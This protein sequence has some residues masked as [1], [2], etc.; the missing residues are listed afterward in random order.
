MYSSQFPPLIPNKI[1]AAH[2]LQQWG[3]GHEESPMTGHPLHQASV[4]PDSALPPLPAGFQ[5]PSH[6]VRLAPQYHSYRPPQQE[7]Q[8]TDPS[9]LQPIRSHQDQYPFPTQYPLPKHQDRLCPPPSSSCEPQ[10]QNFPIED[11]QF[12]AEQTLGKTDSAF[13]ELSNS[14]NIW[15]SI[16][17]EEEDI[18][19]KIKVV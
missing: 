3:F 7:A 18:C 1:V 4:R 10:Q 5:G 16:Q 6:P 8:P 11:L 13:H 17:E 12:A 2:P 9:D 15:E 19:L 14:K